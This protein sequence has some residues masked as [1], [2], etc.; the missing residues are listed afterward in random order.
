MKE[1]KE[2]WKL[3]YEL[4]NDK[5]GFCD[6]ELDE[7]DLKEIKN[8]YPNPEFSFFHFYLNYCY[9]RALSSEVALEKFLE[10][11]PSFK[12]TFMKL[13]SFLK[14]KTFESKNNPSV[15]VRFSK[16]INKYLET[17]SKNVFTSLIKE[18]FGDSPYFYLEG[19]L[20]S[21]RDFKQK[22]RFGE[23]LIKESVK[24]RITLRYDLEDTRFLPDNPKGLNLP[25][26]L[27]EHKLSN[28]TIYLDIEEFQGNKG[29]PIWGFH[30][31]SR[32][33]AIIIKDNGEFI[34]QKGVRLSNYNPDIHNTTWAPTGVN[35][36]NTAKEEHEIAE[37]FRNIL[38]YITRV[39]ELGEI[40]RRNPENPN[41]LEK[42]KIGILE[43]RGN[44]EEASPHVRLYWILPLSP[45]LKIETIEGSIRNLAFILRKMHDYETFPLCLSFSNVDFHGNPIDLEGT[46]TPERADRLYALWKLKSLEF[47]EDDYDPYIAIFSFLDSQTL[48]SIELIKYNRELTLPPSL[49]INAR[50]FYSSPAE[51]EPKRFSEIERDY[52]KFGASMFLTTSLYRILDSLIVLNRYV[53]R[54]H[55]NIDMVKTFLEVYLEDS[56][57][58]IENDS[59]PLLLTYEILEKLYGKNNYSRLIIPIQFQF[60][61]KKEK[62]RLKI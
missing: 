60:V 49:D 62:E 9:S 33:S 45:L 30:S 48:I 36:L 58:L 28:G 55:P 56:Q 8:L 11:N 29:K 20:I 5:W 25:L 7:S 44:L 6:I 57:V 32:R 2:I 40:E 14:E 37:R 22:I 41:E 47:K 35:L 3:L 46:M 34:E 54:I 13:F 12:S 61:S 23:K 10:E 39:Y 42:V 16:L 1:W 24:R 19:K 53:K 21:W 51:G 31:E 17:S 26:L 4:T 27:Y 59:N 38:K 15:D 52:L 50:K 43:R 18:I